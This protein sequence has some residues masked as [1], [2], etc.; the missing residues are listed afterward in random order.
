FDS[1]G[2]KPGPSAQR[3]GARQRESVPDRR[4]SRNAAS[5]LLGFLTRVASLAFA[6][7]YPAPKRPPRRQ[8]SR[9]SGHRRHAEPGLGC[10]SPYSLQSVPGG[11]PTASFSRGDDDLPLSELVRSAILGAKPPELAKCRLKYPEG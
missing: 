8:M 1:M 10:S 7:D 6:A 11:A 2:P 5:V 4:L 3:R 9:G